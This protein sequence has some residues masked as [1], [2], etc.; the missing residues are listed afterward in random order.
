[1][2]QETVKDAARKVAMEILSRCVTM[3]ENGELL[4]EG[5]VTRESLEVMAQTICHD[6]RDDPEFAEIIA[7]YAEIADA[8]TDGMFSACLESWGSTKQ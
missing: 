6:Y 1:M 5:E 7:K 4:G 3:M 2:Y 8:F